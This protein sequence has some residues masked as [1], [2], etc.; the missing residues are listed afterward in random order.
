[1][2]VH[3]GVDALGVGAAKVAVSLLLLFAGFRAVSD[4]D[5]ARI[6]IAQRFAETP[7]L[8]P[9]GTSWLPLPFW[10][11]GLAFRVF[12][13]TLEVARVVAVTG[14]VV[15]VLLVWLSARWIGASRA[16]AV[17][18]GLLA[19]VF[20][21]SAWL[22]T[23][24]LPEAPTAGLV[25]FALAGTTRD[26]ARDRWAS[27]LAIAAACLSRYEA[28]PVAVVVAL[29]AARDAR[30]RRSLAL[31]GVAVVALAPVA[32]WF[33]HGHAVHGDALFFFRRVAAYKQALGAHGAAAS[34]LFEP[35]R[36]L[37]VDAPEIVVA[38]VAA[39]ALG[40]VSR[41]MLRP[42]L[43]ALALVLFLVLGELGGGGPTHHAARALL[44]VWYVGAVAIGEAAGRLVERGT[45]P[46]LGFGAPLG[47][48][49]LAW[50]VRAP[51]PSDFADRSAALALG[52]RAREL[53]APGLFVDTPDYAHLAVTAA[54]GRPSR[55]VPFDDRDPRRT[56]GADPFESAAALRARMSSMPAAWLVVTRAHAPIALELG[57]LR[58]EAEELVL[59]APR[60]QHD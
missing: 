50:L 40:G 1:V 19:A 33:L 49:V 45:S 57:V 25:V 47:V 35:L 24:A 32:A 37:L 60:H 42:A 7:A 46:A 12:G 2:T 39:L 5:Y 29:A 28:W 3:R 20:P 52:T 53:S 10:I 13:G 22:G 34:T 31:L 6:V 44:A 48:V 14:G 9:S 21:W 17:L 15:A 59:I 11:Y 41:S 4:D 36:A 43:G 58:A 51:F 8:D 55:V 27:G 26:G 23:A 18:A 16:G 56:R 30:R 54:F 38:V